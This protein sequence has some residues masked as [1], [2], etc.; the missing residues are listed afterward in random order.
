LH[1]SHG[2]AELDI[3]GPLAIAALTALPRALG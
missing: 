3:R 2:F 1:R